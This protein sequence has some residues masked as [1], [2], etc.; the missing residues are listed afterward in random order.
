MDSGLWHCHHCGFSGCLDGYAPAAQPPLHTQ[1]RADVISRIWSESQPLGPKGSGSLY[2]RNRGFYG[3]FAHEYPTTLRYHPSL[4]CHHGDA[5][6][7]HPALV[8]L[9]EDIDG[10]SAGIIR[11]Y[12]TLFG[13]KARIEN[14]KRMLSVFPGALSGT[15]VQLYEPLGGELAIAE[16]VETALAVRMLSGLPVWAAGSAAQLAKVEVPESVHTVHVCPDHDETG[17]A[18]SRTLA[19]RMLAAGKAVRLALP[20]ETGADWSDVSRKEVVGA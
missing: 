14:P 4:E 2:L 10:R 1:G 7:L 8:A 12:L 20:A 3:R 17:L 19:K 9:F 15:A 18:A 16:G 13:T 5:T 11:I 6:T